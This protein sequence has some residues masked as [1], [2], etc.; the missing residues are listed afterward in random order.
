M[1]KIEAFILDKYPKGESDEVIVCYTKERG[2]ML[3]LARGLKKHKS[4]LRGSL[5]NYNF[6]HVYFVEGKALPIITDVSLKESFPLLKKDPERV[7]SIKI[8][9]SF[10]NKSFPQGGSD[11]LL[12]WQLIKCASVLNNS[13]PNKETLETIPVFFAYKMLNMH[14]FRPEL[15]YCV[16]CRDKVDAGK[17]NWFSSSMGGVIDNKCIHLDPTAFHIKNKALNTLKDWQ[18][19]TLDGFISQGFSRQNQP[20]ITKMIEQFISWHLGT[21][22]GFTQ[23]SEV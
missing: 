16:S 8:I 23:F 19:R 4:K 7:K 20:E 13:E 10:I 21:P 18:I 11:Y 5:Q 6:T 22:L 3:F 17:K 14:G 12:W 1:K 9:T 2:K 15:D